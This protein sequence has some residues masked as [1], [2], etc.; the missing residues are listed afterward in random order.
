MTS[1]LQSDRVQSHGEAWVDAGLISDDQLAAIRRF[2]HLER[3][4]PRRFSVAAEVAVYLGSLLALSG[5]AMVV[6]RRWDGLSFAARLAVALLL[7]IVG[8]SAGAWSYRQGESGTD[9]LAGFLTAVGLAGVAFAVGVTVDRLGNVS[10]ELIVIVSGLAVMAAGSAVWRNRARPLEFSAVVG[11]GVA[12]TFATASLLDLDVW[13]AGAALVLF[14]A[15]V[16]VTAAF[17]VIRPSELGVVAGAV[18]AYIGA[19]TWSD[20][21][22]RLGAVVALVVALMLVAL[23]TRRDDP[24]PLVLGVVGAL[25]ATQA[26]LATTFD[27]ALAAAIV[28][29]CGIVLVVGVIARSMRRGAPPRC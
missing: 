3:P 13:V 8:F 25:I 16:A 14:G 19:F 9:R 29:L 4:V 27:G 11:A 17:G 12:V 7:V 2:E 24:P 22:E 23:A 20:I 28:A 21:D 10:D 5:G 18:V 1:L 6:A 26:V 15:L